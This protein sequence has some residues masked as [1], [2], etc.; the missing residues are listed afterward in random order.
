[1]QRRMWT[2]AETPLL[3]KS[4]RVRYPP[5]RLQVTGTGKHYAGKPSRL[6]INF[7]QV[8]ALILKIR[9]TAQLRV[10]RWK[11]A[12]NRRA[13]DQGLPQGQSLP[14]TS[15]HAKM[16]TSFCRCGLTGR[17]QHFSGPHCDPQMTVVTLMCPRQEEGDQLLTKGES[18]KNLIR[19]HREL[20][21]ISEQGTLSQRGTGRI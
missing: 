5:E 20:L 2:K 4:L 21:R 8:K 16:K 6:G 18:S 13:R 19:Q 9:S 10:T 17:G 11:A 12:S 15:R 1:M 3:R 7:D 14:N